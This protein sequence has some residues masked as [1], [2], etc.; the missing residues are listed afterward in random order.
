MPIICRVNTLIAA[1]LAYA[2]CGGNGVGSEPFSL[3]NTS[4]DMYALFLRKILGLAKFVSVEKEIQ[5]CHRQYFELLSLV[6][7]I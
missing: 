4:L 2:C 6:W 5:V 7:A 1:L 3:I